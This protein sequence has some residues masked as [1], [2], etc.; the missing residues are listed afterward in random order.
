LDG[1]GL[2]PPA[3]AIQYPLPLGHIEAY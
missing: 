2:D 1:L 3:S